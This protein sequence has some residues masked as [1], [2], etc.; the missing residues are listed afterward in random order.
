VDTAWVAHFYGPD[1]LRNYPVAVAVDL[2]GD[3][4]VT[5]VMRTPTTGQDIVTIKY[6]A[7]GTLRWWAPYDGPAGRTDE[8]VDVIVDRFG[9]TYVGGTSRGIQSLTESNDG[10]VLKYYP[11][12]DTAWVR[13]YEGAE[14]SSDVL[15]GLAVDGQRNVF[16]A[17]RRVRSSTLTMNEL[18]TTKYYPNG[19]HAWSETFNVHRWSECLGITA[20]SD[21]NALL[22]G[23]IWL[24]S[25]N[26]DLDFFSMMK[27]DPSG[28]LEWFTIHRD[29]LA[30]GGYPEDYAVDASGNFAA[31]GSVRKLTGEDIIATAKFD[32]DGG[33]LWVRELTLADYEEPEGVKI[34]T[35]SDGNVF[36][37]AL[38]W[39]NASDDDIIA[40]KYNANGDSAWVRAIG[41]PEDQEPVALAVDDAGCLYIVAG[42]EITPGFG[43]ILVVKLDPDGNTEWSVTSSGD[44]EECWP[45][46]IAVDHD[47]NVVVTGS[48]YP[49]SSIS[50]ITTVKYRQQGATAVRGSG[51]D[52]APREVT[53]AH[54]YPNPFNPSTTIEY[55]LPAKGLVQLVVFDML[56]RVVDRLVG[57]EM[58]AGHHAVSWDAS[59]LPSGMYVYQLSVNGCCL[60]KK[61]LLVK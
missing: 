7:D 53:L 16:A 51:E 12:G 11:T 29:S 41:L 47:R 55:N 31:A 35:D 30:D 37:A 56:G 34:A 60:R 21:G 19:L 25:G 50:T 39:T 23:W 1:S 28:N 5:G 2:A 36:W 61:M 13:R 48:V 33:L 43:G 32:K 8:P 58:G 54:N 44:A 57:G 46:D 24:G 26:P 4:V 40:V 45:Y 17:V 52:L 59:D 42:T 49:S 10:V 14:A 6:A 18:V 27:Y 15:N 20:D 3:V 38:A 22:A 9:Y